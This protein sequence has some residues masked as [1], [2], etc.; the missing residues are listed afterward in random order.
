MRQLAPQ[1]ETAGYRDKDSSELN[2]DST[3]GDQLED[4]HD[5]RNDQQ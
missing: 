2:S 3:T 1:A 4:K 5:R